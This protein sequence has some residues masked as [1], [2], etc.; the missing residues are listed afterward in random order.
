MSK[1]DVVFK[2][3]LRG[4]IG[5]YDELRYALRSIETYFKDLG[6]V[7]IVG[8]KPH[9]AV[10]VIHIPA[11]DP[12]K[13]NK[14]ANLINKMILACLH[15]E[16]S[17]RFLNFS[18]DFY[19]MRPC[20]VSSFEIPLMANHHLQFNP[21]QRLNRWQ[22]R[23]QRTVKELRARSFRADCYEGHVPYLLDKKKYP[24]AV[25]RYDYGEGDGLC[26]NTL[27]F[28]TTF[29]IGKERPGFVYQLM[30]PVSEVGFIA[31]KTASATCFNT[32]YKAVNQTLIAFLQ[33]KF[34]N[35]SRFEA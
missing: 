17:D 2:L 5:D 27:Y 6:N 8:N 22:K 21:N 20:D 33:K 9:W 29:T 13:H 26:G 11:E 14:D 32:T 30:Q 18:D 28:N 16:T 31:Q 1:V 24:A 10:N 15:P 19:L 25:F 23:L 35:K 3:G 7:I 4:N 34:P 12:Y